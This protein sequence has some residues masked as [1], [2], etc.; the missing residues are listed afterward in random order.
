VAGQKS[1]GYYRAIYLDERTPQDLIY[2]VAKKCRFDPSKIL[3]AVC[4]HKNGLRI[5]LDE[6]VVNEI[7]EGQDMVVEFGEMRSSPSDR[8]E[9]GSVSPTSTSGGLEMRL[10]F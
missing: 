7:P 1:N 5:A 4:V 10:M 9:N 8:G 6:D 2:E 3:R